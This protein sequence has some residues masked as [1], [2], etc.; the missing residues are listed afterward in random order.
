MQ[1]H[2][3]NEY[4]GEIRPR[5][6]PVAHHIVMSSSSHRANDTSLPFHP[7]SGKQFPALY[8]RSPARNLYRQMLRG[9]SPYQRFRG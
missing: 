2:K 8:V 1:M 6:Q 4:R 9:K 7:L 3:Q 5:R